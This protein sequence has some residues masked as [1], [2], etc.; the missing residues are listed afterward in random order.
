MAAPGLARRIS[1]YG[2]C[3][4]SAHVGSFRMQLMPGLICCGYVQTCMVATVGHLAMALLFA[5]PAWI[6]WDGRT[7]GVFVAFVLAASTLPDVDLVLQSVGFGVKH[8]GV[9]HTALFV[10][11]VALVAGMLALAV[12]R[13]T[14]Q[15]WWRLTED[16]TIQRGTLFLFVAGGFVLGGLSH[17]FGDMLAGDSYEPIEPLWPVIGT[18]VEFPIAHYTSPWLNGIL[19]LVAI[20]LHFA[21]IYSGLFP[22]EHRYQHWRQELTT[23]Q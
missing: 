21:V 16:G 18:Q 1:V 5:L 14:L 17:L 2:Y 6:L 4:D 12:L 10:I 20:G 11:V 7:G 23:E 9:T 15:R 19:L 3:A 8:H 13:P 22:V